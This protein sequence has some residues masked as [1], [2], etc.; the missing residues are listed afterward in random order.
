MKWARYKTGS[1]GYINTTYE[2]R[3]AENTRAA[4]IVNYGSEKR[5]DT[6]EREEARGEWANCYSKTYERLNTAKEMGERW[7]CV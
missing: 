2:L 6:Y 7:I 3:N 4:V 5:L 1:G